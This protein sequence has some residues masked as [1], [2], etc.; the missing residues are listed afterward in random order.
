MKQTLTFLIIALSISACKTLSPP[1]SDEQDKRLYVVPATDT[2]D[3]KKLALVIGNRDYEYGVLTNTLNDATDVAQVLRNI[4][5]EVMLKTNLNQRAMDD[6]LSEFGRRLS[7][8]RSVGWFYYSGHGARAEG[9]NYLLPIDN[10]RIQDE[11]GLRYYAIDADKV[12]EIMQEA[13]NNVNIIVLDA[14][15]DNPYRGVG[16]TLN[17]GW[18]KMEPSKGTIIAFAT[19][20]GKTAADASVNGRNGL[21]ASHLVTALENAHKDHLRVDD[22]FMQISEAVTLE[23]NGRQEPWQLSSLKRPFC[24]GGCQTVA[25]VVVPPAPTPVVRPK[26][27]P[28][29][30]IVRPPEPMPEPPASGVFRDRLAD[31]SNGP[32]MVWIPAGRFQMGDLQ[33]GGDSDE[34][35][36]HWVSVQRFAMG[37]H[38]V[39]VG[40][41]LRFV[42]ATGSHAPEWLERGSQYNIK[43][44]TSAHYKKLGSALTDENHPIVGISWDDATAYAKW[45]TQQTEKQY[46]L[47]TEAEWEYAARAGTTTKYWWG[48]DIGSN[49]ANCS[50]SSCGDRFEYTAPVGSF[51]ANPFGLYDTVVNVWEWTCS[52]YESNYNRKEKVCIRLKSGSLRA[53]RGGAWNYEPWDVRAAYR[54]WDSRDDRNDFVGLR[55]ARLNP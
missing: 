2:S 45:L 23:S 31:G 7:V 14:C 36:V 12:L 50:N 21:F 32:E 47:P 10:G 46:R 29:P 35:P 49:K 54:Y 39:T 34:K 4:G 33:G 55:L 19:D 40:E 42:R 30:A 22:M 43:T 13:K 38:E 27:T 25:H 9:K 6:A 18:T 17:K 16:K 37:T 5:F 52:E 3:I 41:Y 11:R 48:N 8:Q 26:P 1:I 51:L 15:R 53:L 28:S 20:S 24:F 44:G